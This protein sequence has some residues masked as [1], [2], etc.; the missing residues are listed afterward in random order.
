VRGGCG[1]AGGGCVVGVGVDAA[2]AALEIS[3][4]AALLL[5]SPVFW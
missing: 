2:A 1:V 4:A 5:A 3:L